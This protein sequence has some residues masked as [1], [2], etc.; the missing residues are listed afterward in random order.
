[1]RT[2]ALLEQSVGLHSGSV[3]DFGRMLAAMPAAITAFIKSIKIK[4]PTANCI[5]FRKPVLITMES[6]TAP[7]MYMM[8]IPA[9][10]ISN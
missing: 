10:M 3:A 2:I 8:H 6:W 5:V 7:K 1:M 4:K 9:A